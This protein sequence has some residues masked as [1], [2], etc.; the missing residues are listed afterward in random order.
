MTRI[1]LTD[2]KAHAGAIFI[3]LLVIGAVAG[4]LASLLLGL[5]HRPTAELVY[6]WPLLA[7]AL[8]VPA[9]RSTA[10][11]EAVVGADGVTIRSRGWK[12]F[13]PLDRIT[14]IRGDELSIEILIRGGKKRVI[15]AY[16]ELSRERIDELAACVAE[17]QKARRQASS[18]PA[19]SPHL[20]RRGRTIEAWRRHLRALVSEG[21]DYRQA[22]LSADDLALVLE[23]AEASPEQRI[24]AALALA[25]ADS[26][27]ARP[28]IRIAADAC[29]NEAVRVALT[30]LAEGEGDE[31]A[32][33]EALGAE[34]RRGRARG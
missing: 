34:P 28:R 12:R 6:A 8:G 2:R 31:Q 30:S 29:A 9:V 26:E 7:L 15:T 23:D 22:S 4:Y 11:T 24:G 13:I 20:E 10:P 27:T 3:M 1:R 33:E 19:P 5:L 21:R 17:A 18:P 16:T 14:L 25:E 32:L